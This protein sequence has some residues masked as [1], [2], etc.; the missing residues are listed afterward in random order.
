MFPPEE[1]RISFVGLS[2]WVSHHSPALT[3]TRT[4][5]VLELEMS[6]RAAGALASLCPGLWCVCSILGGK[7]VR[8]PQKET[9]NPLVDT[10][11][12]NMQHGGNLLAVLPAEAF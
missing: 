8:E 7:P 11:R 9:L 6:A 5:E 2:H 4:W 10:K 1:I 12:C 3:A